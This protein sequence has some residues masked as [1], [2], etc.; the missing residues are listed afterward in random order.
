MTATQP[1]SSVAFQL[2]TDI[3]AQDIYAASAL[4][5]YLSDTPKDRPAPLSPDNKGALSHIIHNA[6]SFIILSL[7]HHVEDMSLNTPDDPMI[8][9]TL[10]LSSTVADAATV[11][12]I[13]ETAIASYTQ[14][15]V[16][17]AEGYPDLADTYRMQSLAILN[18]L[19]TLLGTGTSP[20]LK[21]CLF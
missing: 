12:R 5:F 6:A 2:D 8:H 18:D 19:K 4:R 3:I 9:L 7:L 15:L 11:R 17:A 16:Y 1:N 14:H 13:L 10:K 21:P 20:H